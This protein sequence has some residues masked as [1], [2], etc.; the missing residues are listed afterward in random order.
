MSDERPPEAWEM[1][2]REHFRRNFLILAFMAISRRVGWI[3]KTESII[4]PGFIYTLTDSSAI[5]G[6]LPLIS[7]SGRSFPQFIIAH[8]V[9]RLKLKW[10]AIFAASLVMAMTWGGLSF[11]IFL[12]PG[13]RSY[14]ILIA[15]FLTYAL[16]W[17][18]NGGA[19]LLEGVLH[20]KLVPANRRG[21]LLAASNAIGCLLAIVAVYFLL[22]R[23]LDSGNSG[24]SM[25]FGA[26]SVLFF[27]SAFSVLAIKEPPHLSEENSRTFRSFVVDS[28]SIIST[29]KNFRR[30]IYV[31]SMFYAF[32]FLFPHYTVFGMQ[33]LG[34]KGRSFISFL[35]A[36][37]TVNALGSLI[38]GYMADRR[39]N[40][41]VLTIL[42]V[43]GGCVPLLALGIAALPTSLGRN[44][45][46]LVFACIGVA[47]VLQRILVNYV[48]EIC[49]AERHSQYLGTMN[50]IL[51][52]PTMAS[53]LV[54]YAIDYF[55]FRPIF[56]VCSMI[57]FCG[58]ILSLKLDEP[59]KQGN[60]ERNE[61]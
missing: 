58:A 43:A 3:F 13:A 52:L 45:Y 50:L 15:F 5:R 16:F 46:W 42:I 32:H 40:K 17:I 35:I 28:A 22:E 33:S 12:F 57:V 47:P 30:L 25:I 34:L 44:L 19:I 1:Q 54:G 39:G 31:I 60:A 55:S 51:M 37:N 23:W 18:A 24:Y 36:Q 14:I 49:P 29:D 8:W 38:M 61:F 20:G 10:P 53:P 21:R 2:A 41:N 7:R 26:T 9:N 48:L 4:M 56:I 59:R 27:V 11:M 6:L